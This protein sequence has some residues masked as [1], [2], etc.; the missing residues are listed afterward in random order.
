MT[1]PNLRMGP[2]SRA[3][4]MT[5]LAGSFSIGAVGIA[6]AK[7]GQSKWPVVVGQVTKVDAANK[8][9][10]VKDA[11]GAELQFQANPATEVEVE[12]ERPPKF[13]WSGDF[14]DVKEGAWVQVK[15][16]GSGAV[17]SARDIDIKS[18]P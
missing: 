11:D 13:S 17:K 6:E 8:T 5:L 7:K 9:F 16:L 15:Y 1:N 4:V 18:A 10:T 14:S 3:L 2:L 12:R